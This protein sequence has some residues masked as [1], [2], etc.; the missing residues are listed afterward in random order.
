MLAQ[1]MVFLHRHIYR[2]FWSTLAIF[3]VLAFTVTA[4]SG[5]VKVVTEAQVQWEQYAAACGGSFIA[6]PPDPSRCAH[7]AATVTKVWK[8][9]HFDPD[10]G[11]ILGYGISFV[12]D[13]GQR[14]SQVL[15]NLGF[16]ESLDKGAKLRVEEYRGHVT[17]VID[18]DHVYLTPDA[19]FV[20]VAH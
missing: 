16:C 7:R 2:L 3:L 12:E 1:C 20:R 19:W 4:L 18:G 15:T 6:T 9:S 14:D 17:A 13:N 11:D 8:E 5:R 10:K